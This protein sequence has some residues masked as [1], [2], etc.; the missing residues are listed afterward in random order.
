MNTSA[1]VAAIVL[2]ILTIASVAVA[3][4]SFRQMREGRRAD[5]IDIVKPHFDEISA[6][7]EALGER[8]AAEH[9]DTRDRLA[10]IE[11]RLD[12]Q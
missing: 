10:K 2:P 3:R 7:V 9:A 1:I 5:I 11:E 8:N 12:P 6:Q 4:W